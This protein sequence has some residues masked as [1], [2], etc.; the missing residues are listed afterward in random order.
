MASSSPSGSFCGG[1]ITA[2]PS[3]PAFETA[4]LTSSTSTKSCTTPC[5]SGGAGQIPPLMPRFDSVSM[6]RYPSAL[7]ASLRQPN[8][9]V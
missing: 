3:E 8:S 2:A 6:R 5:A 4:A 1:M 7:F 9:A